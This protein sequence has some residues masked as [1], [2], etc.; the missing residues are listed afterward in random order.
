MR[1]LLPNMNT[2][3]FRVAALSPCL[4]EGSEAV[5]TVVQ[6]PPGYTIVSVESSPV[7]DPPGLCTPPVTSRT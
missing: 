3:L 7:Y 1:H 2:T 4:G 5:V 6:D